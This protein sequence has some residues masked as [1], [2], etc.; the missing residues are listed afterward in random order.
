MKGVTAHF[1]F[2]NMFWVLVCL[3]VAGGLGFYFR[4]ELKVFVERL[5]QEEQR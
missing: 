1:E 4:D 2:G 5:R 3:V